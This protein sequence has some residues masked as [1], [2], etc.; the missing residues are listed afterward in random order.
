M[1]ISNR[2]LVFKD[3][4]TSSPNDWKCLKLPTIP[5]ANL[6]AAG[7]YEGAIVYDTT[8]N[9][10]VVSNGTSWEAVTSS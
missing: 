9:K 2:Q 6:P 1:A 10:I 8:Q 3:A 5:T 7:Y 4:N